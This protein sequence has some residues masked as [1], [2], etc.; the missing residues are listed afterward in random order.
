MLKDGHFFEVNKAKI[1][2]EHVYD[3]ADPRRYFEELNDVRYLLPDEAQPVF[4]AILANLQTKRNKPLC[5]LDIGC[6]YGIN[7]TLLKYESSMAHLSEFW[8]RKNPKK[9]PIVQGKQFLEQQMKRHPIEVI[10][11][12]KAGQAVSFAQ[13][14]GLLDYGIIADLE[15][16]TLPSDALDT[17]GD[18]DLVISTGCVGYVSEVTF[19]KLAQALIGHRKPWF[20]NFV[21]RSFAFDEIEDSLG[22]FGYITEKLHDTVFPQRFFASENEKTQMLRKLKERNLDT[23]LEDDTDQLFAEFYLSRPKEIAAQIPVSSL[24]AKF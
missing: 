23:Q 10:G 4:R 7:A 2:M 6:S 14:L 22:Q 24:M 3:Q 16:E 21:L 15:K 9:T 13:R 20:A 11:L 8:R 5:V 12:D 18:V 19:S 1:S 17:L